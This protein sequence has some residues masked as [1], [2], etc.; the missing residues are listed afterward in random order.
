MV[1][2]SCFCLMV[3]SFIGIGRTYLIKEYREN[4]IDSAESAAHLFHPKEHHGIGGLDVIRVAGKKRII[5]RISQ[6]S[7]LRG[8]L[9]FILARQNAGHKSVHPFG[10]R[11]G[12]R[13]GADLCRRVQNGAGFH[14][15]RR[16]DHIDALLFFFTQY[17]LFMKNRQPEDAPFL[18]EERKCGKLTGEMQRSLRL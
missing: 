5:Q 14:I 16:I 8:Q 17:N 6:L 1:V 4:M 11:R 18:K 15:L 7:H 2:M 3:F 13:G 12:T 9:I 10:F